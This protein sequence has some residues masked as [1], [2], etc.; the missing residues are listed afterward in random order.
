[1]ARYIIQ[2]N[3]FHFFIVIAIVIWSVLLVPL[4]ESTE[5]DEV[6]LS[7]HGT[8]YC[9]GKYYENTCSNNSAQGLECD[10]VLGGICICDLSKCEMVGLIPCNGSCL[11]NCPSGM[12]FICDSIKGGTCKE[13]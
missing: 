8:I 5:I 6:I 7:P 13:Y 2:T 9:N 3:Y 1:M 4:L 11:E 12:Q 10:P